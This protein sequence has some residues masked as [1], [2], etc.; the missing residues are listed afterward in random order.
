MES[1]NT[2]IGIVYNLHDDNKRV[3]LT[4]IM[5][6]LVLFSLFQFSYACLAMPEKINTVFK[7]TSNLHEYPKTF[8]VA[9]A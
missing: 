7:N 8:A 5:Q 2:I 1:I 3:L 4:K 9:L 6:T